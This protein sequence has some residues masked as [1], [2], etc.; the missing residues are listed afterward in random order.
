MMLNGG[1][2]NGVRILSRKSV[3]L[4]SQNHV[5]GKPDGV[6]YGLGFGTMSEPWQL[7]ELGSVGS[8]N[9]GGF[10]YTYF[11]DRPQRGFNRHLYGANESLGRTESR[12]QGHNPGLPGDQGLNLLLLDCAGRP[13]SPIMLADRKN[14]T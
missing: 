2:L 4:M 10:Y 14:R 5:Q 13:V 3:E 11:R 9:W 6:D 12:L 7:T 1:E 8:Y